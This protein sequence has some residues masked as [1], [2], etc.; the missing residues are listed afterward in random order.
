MIA[1]ISL[2]GQLVDAKQG[3][4]RE[5]LSVWMHEQGQELKKMFQAVTFNASDSDGYSWAA[6]KANS[7]FPY[8]LRFVIR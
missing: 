2:N 3:D 6:F 5:S 1:T 8:I 4:D 7:S